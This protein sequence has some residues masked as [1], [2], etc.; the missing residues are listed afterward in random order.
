MKARIIDFDSEAVRRFEPLSTK[1]LKELRKE[2]GRLEKEGKEIDL[3]ERLHQGVHMLAEFQAVSEVLNNIYEKAIIEDNMQ[4]A[5]KIAENSGLFEAPAINPDPR[6]FIKKLKEAMKSVT[7]RTLGTI[8]ALEVLR[9]YVK[10]YPLHIIE[11]EFSYVP[12]VKV[13]FRHEDRLQ[14]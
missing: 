10:G 8:K 14:T 9:D 6:E 5:G 1:E 12:K 7:E 2:F 13:Q 4:A 3:E 11:I